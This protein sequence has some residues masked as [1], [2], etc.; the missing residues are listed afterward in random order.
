MKTFVKYLLLFI[1]FGI[2]LSGIPAFSED[3]F[4][5]DNVEY[6][7]VEYDVE[8]KLNEAAAGSCAILVTSL[9][10]SR[11]EFFNFRAGV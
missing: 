10:I 1:C 3:R 8:S 2:L 6:D 4:N 5:A 11:P 9:A 7:N